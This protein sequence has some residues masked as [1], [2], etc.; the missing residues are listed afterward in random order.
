MVT[1]E[2]KI[3]KTCFWCAGYPANTCHLY[4]RDDEKIDRL[5]INLCEKCI[6]LR[7]ECLKINYCKMSLRDFLI[8]MG[9]EMEYDLEK[10]NVCKAEEHEGN[11]CRCENRNIYIAKKRR[12]LGVKRGFFTND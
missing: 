12:E 6:R 2:F 8:K 9:L 10:C 5:D 3:M 11:F 4:Q 1:G 7:E